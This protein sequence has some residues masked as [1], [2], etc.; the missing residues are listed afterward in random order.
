MKVIVLNYPGTY[1]E[2]SDV[3]MSI[4]TELDEGKICDAEAMMMMGYDIQDTHW[5]FF[6]KDI[7]VFWKDEVVPY[8]SL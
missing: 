7:P 3:P 4:A 5:M 8:T 2:V 1:V 6:D